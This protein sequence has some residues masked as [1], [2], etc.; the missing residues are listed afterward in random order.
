MRGR[1]LKKIMDAVNLLSQPTGTTISSL[2]EHLDIGIR[3]AHRVIETLELEWGF[4]IDKDKSNLDGKVRYYLDK[5]FC[6]R[7]FD[8]KVPD[9]NLSMSEII[10]LH[11]LK[12]HTGIYQGTDIETHIESAFAKLNIFVPEGLADKLEKVKSLLVDNKKLVKDYSA[13]DK[14]IDNIT[15]AIMQQ[16]TCIV[17]YHSFSDDQIKKLNIDPLAFYEWN[18]GLYLFVRLTGHDDIRLL[19]V[20]RIKNMSATRDSYE[21]PD[22]FDPDA[23]LDGAFGLIYDDPISV[24]IKFSAGQARYIEERQWAKDQKIEK[25]KDGSIILSMNTSGWFEVKKWLLSYG[26]DAEL[27]APADKRKELKKEAKQLA[28]L[29]K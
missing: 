10:A 21:Y 7:L 26:T 15:S 19:A 13:K 2:C 20:E 4:V 17:D 9:L 6:K 28:E 25:Q 3:Q 16:K 8:M 29:Y 18:G 11:F 22:D 14:I 23:L 12:S 27:L 1:I 5:E 24:K